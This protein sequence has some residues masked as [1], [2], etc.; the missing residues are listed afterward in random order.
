MWLVSIK[1]DVGELTAQR[2]CLKMGRI[3]VQFVY[4][5]INNMGQQV[6]LS[7]VAGMKL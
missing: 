7:S 4:I 2:Y 5:V 1:I 6:K 3:C